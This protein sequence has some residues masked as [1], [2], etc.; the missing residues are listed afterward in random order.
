MREE[1]ERGSFFLFH[2]SDKKLCNFIIN[3]K[4]YVF[5]RYR[6]NVKLLDDGLLTIHSRCKF[7]L[8]YDNHMSIVN[9]IVL[10]DNQKR[11][12]KSCPCL[13]CQYNVSCD[14][15]NAITPFDPMV[16]MGPYRMA[17]RPNKHM[18]LKCKIR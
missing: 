18:C 17:C 6:G 14:M 15:C 10:D 2:M 4:C 1:L 16:T 8:S 3:F 11:F 9:Y 12:L 5:N 7:I 13:K